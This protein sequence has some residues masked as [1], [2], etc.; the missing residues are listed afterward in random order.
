MVGAG[1]AG[2]STLTGASFGIHSS[3]QDKTIK[4]RLITLGKKPIDNKDVFE[5]AYKENKEE[6]GFKELISATQ[7]IALDEGGQALSTWCKA[8]LALQLTEDNIKKV[9]PNVIKYCSFPAKT[10]KEKLDKLGKKLT[11]DW[12][13]KWGKIKPQEQDKGPLQQDLSIVNT[14]I[15]KMKV[16][17]HEDV[18]KIALSTWCSRTVNNTL[19]VNDK[20][21]TIFEKIK[22]RCLE[23]DNE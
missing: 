13:K 23:E 20:Q 5:V 8:S 15:S 6:Q 12:N 7:D 3:L 22:V 14:A 18:W 11:K 16:D 9:L 4:D 2:V 19:L 10:I 17:E 1:F 21:D